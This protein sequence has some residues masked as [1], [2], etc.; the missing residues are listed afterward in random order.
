MQQAVIKWYGRHYKKIVALAV[1]GSLASLVGL[2]GLGL[3]EEYTIA[4]FVG[5][6]NPEFETFGE[7]VV[8]GRLYHAAWSE[9]DAVGHWVER[10]GAGN[11]EFPLQLREWRTG[12]RMTLP[13][14]RKKL[15]KVFSEARIPARERRR[16]AV[17]AD[18]K[19]RVLWVPG[20]ARSTIGRPIAG[21]RTLAIGIADAELP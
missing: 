5:S 8:G 1:A 15:K 20:V 4:S 14:G 21:E 6:D 16:T 11:L 7:F 10:F 17:L 18:A 12:D 3:R 2:I 9:G 19:G 13:Y